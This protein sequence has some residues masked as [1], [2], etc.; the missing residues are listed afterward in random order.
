MCAAGLYDILGH[1]FNIRLFR[2]FP[3]FDVQPYLDRAA[4]A[5]K[6]AGM[7][8]DVNTGTLYR[9]PV[10]EI[11]PYPA[12]MSTASR[13]GLPLVLSSDAHRPEDCGLY[14]DDAEAYARTFGYDAA[15]VFTA[16]RGMPHQ[17]V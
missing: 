12:F 7:A 10:G 4:G 13:Y 1:P 3:V 17:F 11:S 6:Q 5:L 2:H 15:L 16:R 14:I 9:Y 8:I